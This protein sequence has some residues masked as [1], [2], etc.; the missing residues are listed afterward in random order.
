MIYTQKSISIQCIRR[1]QQHNCSEY[2]IICLLGEK[3]LLLNNMKGEKFDTLTKPFI[4]KIR[5]CKELLCIAP[6]DLPSFSSVLGRLI[7]L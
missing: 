7:Q 6:F 4:Y 3:A 5:I 1:P 2:R